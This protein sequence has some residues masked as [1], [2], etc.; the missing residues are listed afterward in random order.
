MRSPVPLV[1]LLA[2]AG[3]GFF[4][5]PPPDWVTNR[6]PLE[7]CGEEAYGHGEGVDVEARECLIAAFEAGRGAELITTMTSVEG[8][9]ITRY[10]RVH[11]NGTV[12]IFHD[13]T[14]DQYGSGGWERLRCERL[15]AVEGSDDPDVIGFP[16]HDVFVE[17]DCESLP[18]P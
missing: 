18:V 7:P 2:L 4:A 15:V 1:V 11:E 10:I 6:Q 12:E 17:L 9:P 3:C 16:E 13:A 5:A 8:D 14:Q